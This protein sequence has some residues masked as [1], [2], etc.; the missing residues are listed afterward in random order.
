MFGTQLMW[1][2]GNTDYVAIAA[3]DPLLRVVPDATYP[4]MWRVVYPDG[5]LGDRKNLFRA[6]DEATFQMRSIG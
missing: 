2:G 3:G 4:D 1:R 5:E 6:Q